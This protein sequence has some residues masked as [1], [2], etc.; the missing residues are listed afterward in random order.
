MNRAARSETT[1]WKVGML[2][3]LAGALAA[4][5]KNSTSI[6]VVVSAPGVAA[7]STATIIT[8]GT[9]QFTASVTGI[10]TATVYWRICLPAAEFSIQPTNCTAIPGVTASSATSL[11]GYG[12]ISQ[13]GLYTAPPTPPA[14]NSFVIMAISSVSTHILDTTGSVNS[15][16]G[17][18]PAKV[19]TGVRVQVF[20]TTSTIGTGETLQLTA[21]VTGT[22]NKGVSWS[23]N[24]IAGGNSGV[25]LICPNSA[26]TQ[27][28]S[29]GEY[30]APSTVP[31]SG[32]TI[33]AA[34]SADPSQTGTATITVSNVADAT[35][36]SIDPIVT[37][38]GAAQQNVYLTGSNFFTTDT[39]YV[40]PP[41][42][43]ASAVPTTF[44]STTLL[45]ATIPSN[46][47]TL[48]GQDQISV[49]R[50]NGSPNSPGPLALT[51]NPTRPAIVAAT[52]DSVSQTGTGTV[53]IALTGGFFAPAATTAT[54]NGAAVAPS[55]TSSRQLSVTTTA[56]ALA[57]G[58]YPLVVQNSGVPSG[59][60]SMA[61]VNVAVTPSPLNIPTSP[62]TGVSLTGATSPATPVAIA[63]DYALGI[64][65]VADN[66]NNKVWFIG[67]LS[68]TPPTV[69]GSVNV[70]RG[71]TGIAVDDALHVAVVVNSTDQT[72][73][74]INLLTQAVT[75]TISVAIGPTGGSASGPAPIPYSV[76]VNSLTH[77]GI[78]A[79]E[80]FNEATTFDVSS[81][82]I[83]SASL[84]QIG[85]DV[86]APIGTGSTPAIA[87]DEPLN[88]AV[89]TPGGGGAQTTTIV[90]LG[91]NATGIMSARSPQVIASLALSTTGVGINSETHQAL[92]T[93]PSAGNL[94]SFSLLD[95]SVNFINFTSNGIAF[96]QL[97]L[98]AGWC[99][100]A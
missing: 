97:G 66:A 79:Y 2:L 1:F 100:P 29:A 98:T 48:A 31:A 16:F 19:D 91:S 67:N 55:I 18:Q 35:L 78:V 68:A 70:G 9:L 49:L 32:V 71:P 52:P 45:R 46:L 96:D 34:S 36:T 38:Q 24:G 88:W 22:T 13:T 37:L 21:T 14:P 87:V 64:A 73:S 69:T 80:S 63:I 60:P 39:V 5:G 83:P 11:S 25:G 59:Q 23:V 26:I 92:F 82:T 47:L 27:P 15:D 41:S 85:G 74:T 81:G 44:I 51:V 62:A 4:C 28:C 94:A 43:A 89:V 17:I 20:P 72:V 86:T 54:F 53:S 33:T 58:L 6:G 12:S 77:H 61:A 7:G 65:A 50:Q 93:N 3:L 99:G 95:N 76:G 75:S 30:F 40:A 8:N 84:Q 42:Q 57:P 56:T 10:S 90:D